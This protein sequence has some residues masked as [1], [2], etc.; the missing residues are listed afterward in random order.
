MSEP[1]L[2]ITSADAIELVLTDSTVSMR[3]SEKV[4][5]EVHAEIAAEP[6][7]QS[8]GLAGRFARFVTGA[9]EK[10]INKTIEYPL[11]DVTSAEYTGGA[12]VFT[13]THKQHP[14]FE[15]INVGQNGQNG[16]N[17]PVL[18]TFAPED[19]QAFVAKF[20]EVKAGGRG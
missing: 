4:R 9:V 14:S 3:F 17:V 8:P 7:I 19:A 1:L 18:Q 13:Y 20:R 5:G 15:S 11:A 2:A 6:E 12:L 16:K 10:F